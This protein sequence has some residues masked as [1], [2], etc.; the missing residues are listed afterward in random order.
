MSTKTSERHT[1]IAWVEDK[2]GVLNRVSGLFGR[3]SFNIE[4]LTVGHTET[5]GVSRMTFVIK[6]TQR[7][8]QQVGMQLYKL[9][10][11][12]NVVNVTE[13]PHVHYE[14]ALIKVNATGQTR[15]EIMQLV[16][17]YR[18]NIVDVDLDSVMIRIVAKEDRVNA[19]LRLL[20]Q[21]GI[22][23]MVRTGRLAMV[24]GSEKGWQPKTEP[25]IGT[26]GH[27]S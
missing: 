25:M 12:L 9:I 19:L 23:E 2:P 21:F 16:D 24:R 11:V 22:I 26:N 27:Q 7:D 13:Q 6:G 8:A 3:R 4:S 5:P 15:G 14:M 17:I 10:N 20:D 1:F 18:A